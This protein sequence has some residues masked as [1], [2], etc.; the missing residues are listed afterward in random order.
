MSLSK[1][2]STTRRS[3]WST[4]S[5]REATARTG[6]TTHSHL[7]HPVTSQLIGDHPQHTALAHTQTLATY[8]HTK[9]TGTRRCCSS[10]SAAATAH[11]RVVL[12]HATAVHNRNTGAARQQL[13]KPWILRCEAMQ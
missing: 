6:T 11:A 5:S 13:A 8:H 2:G 9:R 4:L 7:L 12:P 3:A 1:T 10:E